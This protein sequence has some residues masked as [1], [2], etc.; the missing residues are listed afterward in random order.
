MALIRVI[1]QTNNESSPNNERML[2]SVKIKGWML[3]C[4][5]WFYSVV[6]ANVSSAW[7]ITGTK[8]QNN[9]GFSEHILTILLFSMSLVRI[10]PLT[11]LQRQTNNMF[12]GG[13]QHHGQLR[14]PRSS[15]LSHTTQRVCWSD[16]SMHFSHRTG[17]RLN[18]DPLTSLLWT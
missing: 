15:A 2:F 1:M 16:S 8:G 14:A 9:L 10:C 6:V 4:S 5:Y 7:P 17:A 3:D 12:Q 13:S 18:T 11:S